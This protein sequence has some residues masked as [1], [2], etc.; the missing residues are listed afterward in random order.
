MDHK[1][2]N[3][4]MILPIIFNQKYDPSSSREATNLQI[5]CLVHNSPDEPLVSSTTLLASELCLSSLEPAPLVAQLQ[6]ICRLP[7]HFPGCYMSQNP[8]V[9]VRERN[10]VASICN[11]II[12]CQ[13]ADETQRKI[14][15]CTP[16][17]D[18]FETLRHQQ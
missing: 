8:K 17:Y 9:I 2:L 10:E 16:H 14:L 7:S 4:N 18:K 13:Y 15:L 1:D 12:T 5:S 11:I 6:R 3:E